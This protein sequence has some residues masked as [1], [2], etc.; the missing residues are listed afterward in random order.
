MG[1]F[2]LAFLCTF[3]PTRKPLSLLRAS[4]AQGIDTKHG[5][6]IVLAQDAPRMLLISILSVFMFHRENWAQRN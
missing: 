4:C 3:K 6:D 1:Y 2:W 5:R